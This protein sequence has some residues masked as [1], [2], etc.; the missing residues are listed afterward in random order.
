VLRAVRTDAYDDPAAVAARGEAEWFMDY[1]NSDG[2][3]SEMCGNGIRVFGRY[4]VNHQDVDPSAPIAVGTRAGIKVLTFS[5]ADISVDMGAPAILGDTK[6]AV[7]SRTWPALH[8]SMT[9]PARGGADSSTTSPRPGRWP[10]TRRRA[11]RGGVLSRRRGQRRVRG[12]PG[13]DGTTSR[14]G[15]TRGAHA[16]RRVAGL[17]T[18]LADVT[19]VEYRQLRLERVVLVGVWTEGTSADAENSLAELAALAETA[20]SQV[21]EA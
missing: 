10:S 15:C 17:S 12:T 2:S 5:G 11:R 4:L 7:G 16:L 1:R 19:E 9:Q 14:C 3:L 13:A 18:E 20:G 21:L 6:V 8:V